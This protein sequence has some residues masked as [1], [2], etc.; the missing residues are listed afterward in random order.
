MCGIVGFSGHK[1]HAKPLLLEGL[2]RLEYRGYDSAGLALYS[3]STDDFSIRRCVGAV[4]ALVEATKG[5]GL[6]EVQ[7]IAHTRWATHGVPSEVNAHPHLAGQLVLVHNGII[8][9]HAQLRRDLSAKGQEFLSQTDTEVFAKLIDTILSGLT[10][11]RKLTWSK[12]SVADRRQLVLES[13]REAMTQVEGHYSVLFMVRGLAGSLFGIQ[14]GAPLVVGRNAEGSLVASDLQAVLPL[15]QDAAFVSVGTLLEADANAVRFFEA[16][17]LKEVPVKY[18]KIEWSAEKVDKSGYESYMMKEIF[19]QPIVIADTLSGRMPPTNLENFVWDNPRAHEALWRNVKK[20][21]LIGCGTAYHAAMVAK[22]DFERWARLPVEVDIASEFRYRSPVL[23]PGTLVGVI[24]QSGETADTLAALRLANEKGMTTFSV[25]NV[26]NSTI[27]RESHFQYS[28]KAGP[29]IGVASTKAF[30][31]QLTVLCS[32]AHDVA[33]L[34][35][36]SGGSAESE[37]VFHALARLPQDIEAVLASAE[38]FQ[39]IGASLID[40]KTVLFLGRGPLFPIALEGALKLKEITYYHAE[41][42]AAGELKHGPL[43]L[44]DKNLVAIV[45]APRDELHAKTLSNLEEIKSRG[46]RIIGIGEKGDKAFEALC[47]EYIPMPHASWA[48]APLLYVVPTQLISYGLAK[49]L[50]RNIDKP[51]NLAKS[52]TVE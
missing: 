44:V 43:A 23:E 19:Q 3:P 16:K 1:K 39:K 28:T 15:T 47:N 49:A 27:M 13:M 22:Y 34:R 30:T 45:M 17:T 31:A 42:Y 51:R 12:A 35:G 50:G 18:E 52:V 9:N 24:S 26:P 6:S 4:D 40:M 20:V 21:Y 14:S 7:G 41:G 46:A 36:L 8:E 5:D 38:S 33:R 10:Q 25:C 32:L 37:S 2:K 11:A 48:A 29:E